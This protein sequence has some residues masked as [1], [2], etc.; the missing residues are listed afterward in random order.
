MTR[1][2]FTLSEQRRYA[3]KPARRTWTIVR[4]EDDRLYVTSSPIINVSSGGVVE[5]EAEGFATRREA[6]D[7]YGSDKAALPTAVFSVFGGLLEPDRL[8][9][10]ARRRAH[11]AALKAAQ[12]PRP[13]PHG[14]QALFRRKLT[15]AQRRRGMR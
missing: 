14:Q 3:G 13:S 8:E 12:E 5:I 9:L 6:Q 10:R 2:M 11:E 15:G 7:W 1:S 4:L